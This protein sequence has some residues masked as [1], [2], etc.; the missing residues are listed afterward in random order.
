MSSEQPKQ[1]RVESC[2]RCRFFEK[3][4]DDSNGDFTGVCRR[5]PPQIASAILHALANYR[6]DDPG[7]AWGLYEEMAMC[8]EDETN[9]V[10]PTVSVAN[11]DWC[12]EFS[13]ITSPSQPSS[14]SSG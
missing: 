8:R 12:G 11:G 10:W 6:A 7:Y 3:F 13:P 14:A 1:E 2:E 4:D 9:W 5:N